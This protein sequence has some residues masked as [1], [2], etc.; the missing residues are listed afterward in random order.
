MPT[1]RRIDKSGL[2]EVSTESAE[3]IAN[4]RRHLLES[5]ATLSRRLERLESVPEVPDPCHRLGGVSEELLAAAAKTRSMVERQQH[6]LGAENAIDESATLLRR[7]ASLAN[8]AKESPIVAKEPSSRRVKFTDECTSFDDDG[9]PPPP[10]PCAARRPG[11]L[12]GLGKRKLSSIPDV[13]EGH[14]STTAAATCTTTTASVSSSGS[15]PQ[16]E[17]ERAEAEG[18]EHTAIESVEETRV[19]YKS[20]QEAAD[21]KINDGNIQAVHVIIL[22]EQL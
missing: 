1:T 2:L 17:G 7:A 5:H 20:G 8:E 6:L 18:C 11:H 13:I 22:S 19:S 12:D 4:R 10:P 21:S 16:P 9:I 3:S 14:G 15:K